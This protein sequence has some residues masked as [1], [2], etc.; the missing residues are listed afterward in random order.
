MSFCWLSFIFISDAKSL[1]GLV[2]LLVGVGEICG[3]LGYGFLTKVFPSWARGFIILFSLGCHCVCF[4]LIF[5]GEFFFLQFIFLFILFMYNLY[6]YA[7]GCIVWQ[8]NLYSNV[9][10]AK[11]CYC[12][13]YCCFTWTRRFR[14]QYS[15]NGN[16]RQFIQGNCLSS[17]SN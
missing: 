7:V 17:T 5:I 13:N 15:N 12:L 2:G 8:H 9:H 10:P 11:R 3:A 6:S 14:V 16:F 4:I 1:V